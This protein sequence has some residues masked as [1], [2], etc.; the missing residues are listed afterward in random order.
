MTAENPRKDIQERK[1]KKNLKKYG[2]FKDK[3]LHQLIRQATPQSTPQHHLPHS[4]WPFPSGSL[5]GAGAATPQ[6]SW[7]SLRQGHQ[8]ARGPVRDTTGD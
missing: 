5:R 7:C 6:P 4:S 2:Q 3:N 8:V 1:L